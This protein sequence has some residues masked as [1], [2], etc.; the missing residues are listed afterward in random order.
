[1]VPPKQPRIAMT[2]TLAEVQDYFYNQRWTDGLPIIPPTEELVEAFLRRTKHSPEEV[3]TNTMWP[4]E[5]TATVEKVAIVGAMAGCKP[6]YMPLLLAIVDAFAKSSFGVFLPSDSSPTLMTVVNGPIRNEIGM[7]AG[8][9][10][11]GPCNQANATIGRF[12]N[13][14]IITLGGLWP[15]IN[16]LS[17]QGN[18]TRYSFCF[19]ENEEKNPWEPFHVS[20]GYKAEDSAVTMFTGGWSHANAM[21]GFVPIKNSL[22]N[23]AKGQVGSTILMAP[24]MARLCSSDGMSKKDVEQF[25]WEHAVEPVSV[26][27]KIPGFRPGEYNDLPDDAL[28]PVYKRKA[29]K[30]IVVGGETGSGIAQVWQLGNLPPSTSSV[31][32][33]R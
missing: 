20:L 2:G 28:V 12:A 31:D 33:W 17:A 16:D 29:V 6:E 3:V 18:P 10:A 25:I 5:F 23:I 24:G 30:V 4:E 32:K 14:S 21:A 15:Q 27:K 19:A 22:D 8:R 11:M 1:M 13:L 9:N 7:N 26:R